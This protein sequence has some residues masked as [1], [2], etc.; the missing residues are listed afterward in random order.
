MRLMRRLAEFP[1]GGSRDLACFLGYGVCSFA[2][3]TR[4]GVGILFTLAGGF[5]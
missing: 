1:A 3:F 5:T 2:Y 4:G